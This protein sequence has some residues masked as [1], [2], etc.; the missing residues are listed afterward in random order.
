MIRGVVHIHSRFSY[1]GSLSLDELRKTFMGQGLQFA[2][3][4]EH[5]DALTAEDAQRFI[6][7]CRAASD[8]RFMFIPGFEA[9]YLGTHV[10][11][12]G[13]R[14]YYDGPDALIR[15]SGDG[16]LLVLAHPHRNGYRTDSFLREHLD[17]VEVWNSQY[18]GIHAP[19]W[20]ALQLAKALRVA[21]YGSLDLHRA[22]H[23]NGPR[24]EL[25]ARMEETDI[26]A[27]LRK[28]DFR[29]RRGCVALNAN[30]DIV[31]GDRFSIAIAG[32]IMPAAVATLQF[33]SS[34]L[35]RMGIRTFGLK[36][37]I[38]RNI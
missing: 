13:A 33:A 15:W 23:I 17:G 24:M 16:A 5:T 4:T 12:I 6:A 30:G 26:L 31:Q 37:W 7:A 32:T 1:D 2:C 35:Y 21:G 20:K 38:R 19:R 8:E 29:I 28:R 11:A 36:K 22:S 25:E 27:A 3:M 34:L 18:D 14:A 10:L 9:P